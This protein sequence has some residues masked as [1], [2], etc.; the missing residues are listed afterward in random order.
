MGKDKN[1]LETRV[2]REELKNHCRLF[3]PHPTPVNSPIN[4]KL[5]WHYVLTL[6]LFKRNRAPG[7]HHIAG[8]LLKANTI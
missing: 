3:P 5:A 7:E 1:I 6:Y 8:D 2:S 4:L